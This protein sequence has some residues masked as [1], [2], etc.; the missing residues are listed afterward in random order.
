M[1]R[2]ADA[3]NVE[4]HP[5]TQNFKQADEVIVLNLGFSVSTEIFFVFDFKDADP[6]DS[7]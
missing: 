1:G 7:L 5:A 3:A 2:G 4:V 6:F